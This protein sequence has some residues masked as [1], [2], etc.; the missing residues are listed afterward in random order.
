MSTTEVGSRC[1]ETA[2]ADPALGSSNQSFLSPSSST[3]EGFS[4]LQQHLAAGERL[5][6]MRAGAGAGAIPRFPERILQQIH[7]FFL[8]C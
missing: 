5:T 8:A 2:G 7:C 1:A 6:G 3:I 4:S